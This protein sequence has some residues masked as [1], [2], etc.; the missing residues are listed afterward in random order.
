MSRREVIVTE[1]QL[2][3]LEKIGASTSE[4]VI[5]IDEVGLGSWAGPVVVAAAV[6]PKDW[7]HEKV[8]DSKL[9]T[10]K[11][12]EVADPIVREAALMHCIFPL[13]NEYVDRH[14]LL[15][16]KDIL[17]ERC[18]LKCLEY[19]PYALIVQDGDVPTVIGDVP[20]NM[21]WLPKADV[22]VPA[23]SAASI[24]AKVYRDNFMKEQAKLYP[25]YGFETNVGYRSPKHIEGLEKQGIT[26]LHRKSYKSIKRFLVS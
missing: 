10:P 17:T 15:H 26:P 14:G 12:R 21:V 16:T 20:R 6:L 7:R 3:A 9:L 4:H 1:P 5:G 2:Q 22:L 11:R 25:G 23:V 8:K 13:D 19:F 18:A 24:L